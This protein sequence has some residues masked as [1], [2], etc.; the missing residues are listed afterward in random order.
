MTTYA[1]KGQGLLNK[2]K[3]T[4]SGSKPKKKN[5]KTKNKNNPVPSKTNKKTT[6]REPWSQK[7]CAFTTCKKQAYSNHYATI[8]NHKLY[9]CEKH[10][11]V[12]KFYISPAK[13]GRP[14]N[15]VY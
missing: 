12:I 7:Y 6:K 5:Y 14:T 1:C 8:G 3:S 11:P 2:R 4:S 9:Y 10:W 13:N 15:V